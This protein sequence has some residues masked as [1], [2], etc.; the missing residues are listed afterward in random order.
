MNLKELL[1]AISAKTIEDIMNGDEFDVLGKNIVKRSSLFEKLTNKLGIGKMSEQE[2]DEILDNKVIEKNGFRIKLFRNHDVYLAIRF[3]KDIIQNL[4]ASTKISGEKV[5]PIPYPKVDKTVAY[6][7]Y[8]YYK[9]FTNDD[10]GKTVIPERREVVAHLV[11][12]MLVPESYFFETLTN[13]EKNM[14]TVKQK[15]NEIGTKM[16]ANNLAKNLDLGKKK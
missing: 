11:G 10:T 15:Q 2:I 1:E 12:G 8:R 3:V 4:D 6:A 9:N 14:G 13:S 16:K 7:E 5:K